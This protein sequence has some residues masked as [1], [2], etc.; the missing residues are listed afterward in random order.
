MYKKR[1]EDQKISSED[2]LAEI[3]KQFY[4]RLGNQPDGYNSG[5]A[6]ERSNE[7]DDDDTM[8]EVPY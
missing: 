4:E 7:D 6:D 1:T 2:R 8:S 5:Y 3:R